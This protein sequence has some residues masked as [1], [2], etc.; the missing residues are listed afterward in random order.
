MIMHRKLPEHF[1]R[2]KHDKLVVRSQDAYAGV[3]DTYTKDL[4]GIITVSVVCHRRR[5]AQNR[6]LWHSKKEETV[7]EGTQDGQEQL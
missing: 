7:F 6:P 3:S 1:I 5:E 2:S 4:L